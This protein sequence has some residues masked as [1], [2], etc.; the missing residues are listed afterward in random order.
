MKYLEKMQIQNPHVKIRPIQD[1][2]FKKYGFIIN[3]FDYSEIETY[4]EENLTIASDAVEYIPALKY[5]EDSDIKSNI[6]N[7]FFGN[8]KVQIGWCSGQNS[9]LNGLEY[10]MGNEFT[11]A[12]TNLLILLGD[13]RDIVDGTYDSKN[14]EVFFVPKGTVYSLYST[15]LHYAPCQTDEKGFQTIVVLPAFTNT[16][17][18]ASSSDPLLFMRNKWLLVHPDNNGDIQAGAHVGITGENITLKY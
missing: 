9:S 8:M 16:A 1:D 17:L 5:F 3:S 4:I 14:I 11:V 18:E 15:T 2:S 7:Q 6:E 10:H 12:L 13:Q